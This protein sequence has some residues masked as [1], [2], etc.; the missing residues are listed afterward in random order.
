[1]RKME[2]QDKIIIVMLI[3]A[4]VFLIIWFGVVRPVTVRLPAEMEPAA[5]VGESAVPGAS[6]IDSE[7]VVVTPAGEPTETDVEIGHPAAPQQSNPLTEAE[8]PAGAIRINAASHSFE[9]NEFTVRA[10][11]AVTLSITS[12]ERT[13]VFAFRDPALSAVAVGLAGGETRVINFNAPA[14]GE[15]EFYSNVPGH[16]ASGKMIV[17]R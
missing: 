4:V 8:I 12:V 11:R 15:Y 7:G 14:V 17:T 16:T 1:M 2:K 10:G 13:I 6:P 5:P 9:P 3:I